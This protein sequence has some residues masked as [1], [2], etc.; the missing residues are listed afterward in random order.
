M[1]R[2]FRNADLPSLTDVWVR[3][4]SLPTA[5]PSVSV[6]MIEQAILS[7]TF[8]DPS[9]LLIAEVDGQVQ[10]W[11]HH[12]PGIGAAA[13]S[14]VISAICLVPDAAA[15]VGDRLVTEAM[16]KIES[17]GVETILAGPLRDDQ[18]GYAGLSP[19]GHGIGI[20]ESE[21][22]IVQL[23]TRHGFSA[24]RPTI[25]MTV[26]TQAYRMGVSREALQL[27]RSTRVSREPQTPSDPGLASAMAHFN[28]ERHRLFDRSGNPLSSVGFWCSD[29]E[30]E[31]MCSDHAILDLDEAHQREGLQPP[32]AFL[33]ATVLQSLSGRHV[34]SVETAID[35]ASVDLL[36]Q[37][38][39]LHF[40]EQERG[41]VWIKTVP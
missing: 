18:H 34:F 14:A 31:V 36:K 5:P 37:L 33:V 28:I 25:R 7:R 1:I 16:K 40:R 8:F 3:H 39:S 6:A 22:R 32:D 35:S 12:S 9:R 21:S 19:I 20:P 11:C 10:G 24:S 17:S 23:L 4:W 27:R 41:N 2:T 26:S 13:D 15:D 38:K 29:P 30:A